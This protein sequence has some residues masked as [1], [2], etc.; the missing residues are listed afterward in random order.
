MRDGEA[1]AQGGAIGAVEVT[2][3]KGQVLA[4]PTLDARPDVLAR[5]R[6]A[7]PLA[8]EIEVGDLVEGIHHPQARIELQ[9]VDDPDLVIEPDVLGPQVAVPI[10]DAAAAY[11]CRQH[12][13]A[14]G[15]EAPLQAIDAPDQGGGKSEPR[16][17]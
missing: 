12:G 1:G 10:D 2:E 14:F 11:P 5:P 7:E 3:G 9:A 4:Q 16:I 6:G 17:E 8:L 15:E 13:A